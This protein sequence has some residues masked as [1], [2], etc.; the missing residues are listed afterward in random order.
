MIES[1][2][3][4]REAQAPD[5]EAIA[6]VHLESSEEAYAPLA[7]EWPAPD[8]AASTARWLNW[9]ENDPDPNR[10]DLVLEL[11]GKIV[12]FVSGGSARRKGIAAEIEIRVIHVLPGHRG[13]GFGGQLWSA[14]TKALRGPDLRAMYLA[15]LAELRCC[16]FYDAHG[17]EVVSRSPRDFH[18]NTVTDLVY[19]W[20]QGHSSELS[21]RA[22]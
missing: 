14:A 21:P 18:G 16:S 3:V 5:A 17:G 10:V 8:H 4:I 6:H 19:I 12:A 7:R 13:K 2:A 9:L 22:R 20:P 11:D 15:T 1:K